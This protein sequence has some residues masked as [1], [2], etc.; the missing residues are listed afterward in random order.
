MDK[1]YPHVIQSF[2]FLSYKDTRIHFFHL[3]VVSLLAPFFLY[4]LFF[5]YNLL[6]Y[7]IMWY[8]SWFDLLLFSLLEKLLGIEGETSRF[9]ISIHF[10]QFSLTAI[11][12]SWFRQHTLH[13][14]PNSRN[15]RISL[16]DTGFQRGPNTFSGFPAH[17]LV[18]TQSN[19]DILQSQISQ[20]RHF[21]VL[22]CWKVAILKPF[23]PLFLWNKYSGKLSKLLCR[24]IKQIS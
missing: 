11:D 18:R 12:L 14:S 8:H 5:P 10:S 9:A 21:P 7:V 1:E 15:L 24:V 17:F 20:V 13:L 23:E 22:L 16:M 6:F 2:H 4:H 19:D 3:W